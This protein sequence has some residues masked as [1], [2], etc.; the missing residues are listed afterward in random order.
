[1]VKWEEIK[2]PFKF[3]GLDIRSI[4]ELNKALQGKW[5]WRFLHENNRL[6]RKIVWSQWGELDWDISG[7]WS[8][9]RQHGRRL[10]RKMMMQWPLFRCNLQWKLGRGNSVRFWKDV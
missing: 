3:G 8:V 9:G 2:K 1:M 5:L 6:W 7:E 10:W 4:V